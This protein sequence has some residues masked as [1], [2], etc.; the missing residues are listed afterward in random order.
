MIAYSTL[1]YRP[2]GA[3]L[4][5][6]GPERQEDRLRQGDEAVNVNDVSMCVYA[7]MYMCIYVYTHMYIYIYIYIYIYV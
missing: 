5:H 1:C 3:R 7:Y 2:P 4:H 6:P